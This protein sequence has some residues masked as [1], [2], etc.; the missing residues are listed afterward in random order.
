MAPRDRLAL[1]VEA[2]RRCDRSSTAG[3]CRAGCLPRGSRSTFTGPSTCFA[4]CDRLRDDSRPRAGGRSRRRCRW[5][6]TVDLVG[7]EAGDLR[8]VCLRARGHLG[9]D[10]DLAA[11]RRAHGRCSS[12]APWWHAPGTVLRRWPRPSSRHRHGAV[13]IAVLA[14]TAPGSGDA[15]SSCFTTSAVVSAACGPSFHLMSSAARPCCAAHMWSATTAT[16]LS[17]RTTW[18]TPLHGHR[19]A[20]RRRWRACRR[21]PGTPRRSR[22]HAG[23]HGVD[24]EHRG[25]V[26]LGRC[27]E[28]LRR[29]A[30]QLPVLRVLERHLLRHR[31]RSPP[32]RPVR[33]TRAGGGSR[34]DRP[35]RRSARQVA[36]STPHALRGGGDEHRA[37]GGAGLAERHPHG[38][39][40]RGPAGRLEAQRR[41]GVERVVGWCLLER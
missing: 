26:H 7:R 13:D 35:R 6:C 20:A 14:A 33:R 36:A 38:A 41:V 9:A 24:A 8:R 29:R 2:G 4:I 27:V 25:A 39:H 18:R 22:A 30:D 23:Q 21:T 31:Q 15:V 10:P 37:R 40:R 11:V 17:S 1:G 32:C 3:T 16:A 19:L 34:R 5:L 28:P 12:S